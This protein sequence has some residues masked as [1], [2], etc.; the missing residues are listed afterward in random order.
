MARSCPLLRRDNVKN[1]K[2]LGFR[3]LTTVNP[4]P[5]KIF[6]APLSDL[7]ALVRPRDEAPVDPAIST[8]Y[9]VMQGQFFWYDIMTTDTKAA[10][11]FY[12]DVVGWGIQNADTGGKEY[13]VFTAN[14]QGVA[15]LM[16]IPEEA[17]KQ[18]VRP[19][20]M[21]YVAVDDVDAAAAKLKREGG[22]VHRPPETVP[23]VIRFAVVS[24]PQ[25]AGFYIARGLSTDSPPPL[26][27]GTAG[28]I[29]WRELFANEWQ[30]AFSFYQ[31]LFG[32]TKA[33]ALDM[34]EMGTYQLFATGAEPVGGMMTRPAAIPRPFWGY[35]FNVP[36]IDAAV[37]RVKAAGGTINMGPHEVPG[38]LWI[39]QCTDP[40]GAYF[41]LV[42]AKR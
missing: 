37:G 40:Q 35:Y 9:S 31:T 3:L 12:A 36:A 22:T 16:P 39:I 25:G 23:G 6:C 1:R 32:W 10:A 34:G 30:A 19:A 15:G 24:D 14:G 5:Q 26:P 21:G 29:G 2:T 7:R 18:G 38:S 20:W 41:A 11:K 27:P 33:D 13:T 17:D 4:G 8:E 42:S 28:T